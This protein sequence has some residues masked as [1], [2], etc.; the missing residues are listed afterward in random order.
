MNGGS[1]TAGVCYHTIFFFKFI[2]VNS[3]NSCPRH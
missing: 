2:R 3:W 1:R